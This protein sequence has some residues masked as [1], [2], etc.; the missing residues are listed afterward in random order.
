[1]SVA[2]QD[3]RRFLFLAA[4]VVL[5]SW[6]LREQFVLFTDVE[7]PI[8]GDVR[9]YVAY[10]WNMIH[11]HTFSMAT[12][13]TAVV[14]PDAFRGPGYPLFIAGNFLI[15]GDGEG[16]YRLT[17]QLQALLGAATV[18]LTIVLGRSWLSRGAALAAGLFMAIWPHH[19]A[20]TGAVL[21]EVLFG[22]LLI[23]AMYLTVRAISRGS[24]WLAMVAGAGFAAAY[25]VN[26]SILLLPFFAALLI[27]RTGQTRQALFLVLVPL[28]VAAGWSL[29]S[30]NLPE[31]ADRPGRATLNLVEGS[32]P[33]YH[34]A[35]NYKDIDPIA[36]QISEQIASEEQLFARSPRRGLAAMSERMA[37]DP[38]YYILWYVFRKPWLLWDWNIR[39][40]W[41]DVYYQK[42]QHS[43]LDVN[44]PLRAIKMTLHVLNPVFFL[45]ALLSG[46]ALLSGALR[47]RIDGKQAPLAGA[48]VALVCVYATVVHTVF[49]AEPRFSIPYRS[50]ELLLTSTALAIIVDR[51]RSR[52]A[53]R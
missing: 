27:L 26:P 33:Q 40:G 22:F 4:I 12:P 10:A 24:R 11:H 37:Q 15:G 41:G 36:A 25:L 39:I 28:L 6:L 42:I 7:Q 51:Y 35:E 31:I 47:R 3:Q 52:R 19:I 45:L 9:Q 2:A 34:V 48:L 32:W 44:P 49:Q 18:A 17:L 21:S 20:A 1:M 23:L 53:P 8:R 46:V 38:N 43:P 14:T 50:F 30:A 13:G 5:L 16:W 29:R